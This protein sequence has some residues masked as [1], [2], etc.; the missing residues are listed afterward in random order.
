MNTKNIW[1]VRVVQD[2]LDHPECLAF[3]PSGM[4]Y[5][6]GEAGQVYRID[7]ERRTCEEIAHSGGLVIGVTVDGD[8]NVFICDMKKHAVLRVDNADRT[9][10]TFGDGVDGAPL[11]IPNFGVFHPQWRLLL[12]GFR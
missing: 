6:G 5:A 1:D 3:G 9:I 2:S 7:L 10:T 11:Q 12:H 8:E 4:L